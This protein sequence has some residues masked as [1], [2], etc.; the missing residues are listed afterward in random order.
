M[1]MTRTEEHQLM[2]DWFDTVSYD[3]DATEPL[4]EDGEDD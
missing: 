4:L 1:E 3:N 2:S